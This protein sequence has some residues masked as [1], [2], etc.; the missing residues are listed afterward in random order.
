VLD[1]PLK[2]S[3]QDIQAESAKIISVVDVMSKGKAVF[4]IPDVVASYSRQG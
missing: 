2:Y 3:S 4:L 1:V